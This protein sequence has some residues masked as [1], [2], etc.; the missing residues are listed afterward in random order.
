M[1]LTMSINWISFTSIYAAR[2]HVIY[3]Q[4]IKLLSAMAQQVWQKLNFDGQY[5]V[6]D[7]WLWWMTLTST[8]YQ[9]NCSTVW[10]TYA[11]LLWSIWSYWHKSYGMSKMIEF[12]LHIYL[13]SDLNDIDLDMS[14]LKLCGCMQYRC[15]PNIKLQAE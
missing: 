5:Q 12:D 11:C 8:C 2:W 7:L 3:M 9:S 4:N 6:F 15:I 14:P 10:D 13:T 1:T